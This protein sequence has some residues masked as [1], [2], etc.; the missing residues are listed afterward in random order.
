MTNLILQE[1]LVVK[2]YPIFLK[3]FFFPQTEFCSEQ[4]S[5]KSLIFFRFVFFW[6]AANN[7]IYGI[8]IIY[9]K[10]KYKKQS[11]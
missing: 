2:L 1:D 5:K 3:H 7:K 10:K 6:A 9:P 8:D 11:Q 4:Q